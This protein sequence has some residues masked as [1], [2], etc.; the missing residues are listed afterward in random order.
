MGLNKCC[1]EN[2]AAI[3]GTEPGSCGGTADTPQAWGSASSCTCQGK[4]HVLS[5]RRRAGFHAAKAKGGSNSISN[6]QVKSEEKNSMND[7]CFWTQG[8]RMGK[9]EGVGSCPDCQSRNGPKD[10]KWHCELLR[11]PQL[12][13]DTLGSRT[14]ENFPFDT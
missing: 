4:F 10:D 13:P 8:Q 11:C 3:P 7:L 14:R 2:F 12:A 9:E 1:S 6:T 5:S